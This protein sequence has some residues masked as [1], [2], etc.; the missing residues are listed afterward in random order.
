VDLHAALVSA[1][2]GNLYV[3]GDNG[4][5][6]TSANLGASW[7]AKPLGTTVSLYGLQDL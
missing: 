6:R 2:D 3:A 7:T 1:A 5:L 4:T